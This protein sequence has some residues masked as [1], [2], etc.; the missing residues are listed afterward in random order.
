MSYAGQVWAIWKR[1][2]CS[3]K[4]GFLEARKDARLRPGDG[5]GRLNRSPP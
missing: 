5:K 2:V 1:T 3:G 4:E